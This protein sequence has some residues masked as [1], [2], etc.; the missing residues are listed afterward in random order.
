M[1]RVFLDANVLFS[2]AYGSPGLRRLWDMARTGRCQ[3]LASAH[4]IEEARRNLDC[5]ESLAELDELVKEVEIVPECDPQVPCPVNLP[6]NDRPVLMA[7]ILARATHLVT[8]D[9]KHFGAY[10]GQ[11]IQGVLIQTPRD[12]LTGRH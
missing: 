8:G 10:R 7:A 6:E 3:L 12:Y 1:D 5:P 11:A 9:L 4:V 2:A